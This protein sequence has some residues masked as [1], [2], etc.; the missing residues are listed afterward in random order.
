M[1]RRLKQFVKR[2]T[3]KPTSP[4]PLPNL[5][6]GNPWS[7]PNVWEICLATYR[8]KSRPSVFEYG[9]G[10]SSISH[11]RNLVS[12]GGGSYQAVEHDQ[13][14]WIEVCSAIL[15]LGAYELWKVECVL[16]G[17]FTATLNGTVQITL[18]CRPPRKNWP[19]GEGNLEWF[20]DYIRAADSQ[21]DLIIV[22][23]RAR[24]A[25]VNYVLDYGLLKPGGA[26][27][28]MEAGRGTDRWLG[29]PTLTGDYDYR[30]AVDRMKTL[31]AV[32]IDGAG[33]YAWPTVGRDYSAMPIPMECCLLRYTA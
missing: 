27:A 3:S 25:C 5:L 31:G 4:T 11:I 1:L 15:K 21:H 18:K 17:D 26:L 32:M 29:A 9:C 28:L 12:L 2:L 22:D 16:Q 13:G 23:G 10:L 8:D 14:W 19:G 33:L 6:T 30:P 20:A 7:S 24:V